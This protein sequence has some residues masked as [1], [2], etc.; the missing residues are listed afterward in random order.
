MSSP[1]LTLPMPLSNTLFQVNLLSQAIYLVDLYKLGFDGLIICSTAIEGIDLLHLS[2]I[3]GRLGIPPTSSND[4][5][6]T[7]VVVV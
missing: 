6:K 4:H 7:D 5:W 1:I 3:V 2:K